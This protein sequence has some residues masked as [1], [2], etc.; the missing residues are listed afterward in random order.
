MNQ[1]ELD[2]LLRKF[3]DGETTLDEEKLLREVLAGDDADKLL[4]Q[5]MKQMGQEIPAAPADLEQSL[6]DMIDE[7]E[8]QESHDKVA[9]IAPVASST[10]RRPAWWAAAASVA[11]VVAAG[12]WFMRDSKPSGTE[13]EGPMTAQTTP[14][15]Q[16]ESEDIEAP[17]EITPPAAQDN[18]SEQASSPRKTRSEQPKRV[19]PRKDLGKEPLLA[20]ASPRDLTSDGQAAVEALA[21]FSSTLNKGMDQFSRAQDK[22]EDINNTI[23]QHLIID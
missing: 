11:V 23:N 2:I 13:V 14:A 18:D 8:E 4:M 16:T 21:K 1:N 20:Q 3:Y 10:W 12:W 17:Q 5:G 9:P 7:W 15:P 6:S 22:I 19:Y